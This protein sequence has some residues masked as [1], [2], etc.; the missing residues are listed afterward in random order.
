M[1]VGDGVISTGGME[2]HLTNDQGTLTKLA[3][4]KNFNDPGL[5]I[6]KQQTTNQDSGGTH[7]YKP[8]M[9]DVPEFV[10]RIGYEIGSP[11]D[12]LI[13]EHLASREVRPFKIVVPEEDGTT[14]DGTGT[15]LLL[16][17]V[18]DDGA[19]GSERIATL[20]GQPSVLSYADS[21]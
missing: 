5:T 20:T 10:A 3:N 16:G 19:L 4:V 9:A 8:G 14:Q 11:T 17:Y 6:E 2:L 18:P 7:T 1:A 21:V 12:L 13:R 15:I